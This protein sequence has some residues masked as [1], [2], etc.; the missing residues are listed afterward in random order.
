MATSASHLW[1][2]WLLWTSE[3]R[4][5]QEGQLKRKT[6]SSRIEASFALR[7]ASYATGRQCTKLMPSENL[8][9]VQCASELACR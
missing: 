9:R 5:P 3:L 7:R 8:S 4:R 6:E 1:L 2:S